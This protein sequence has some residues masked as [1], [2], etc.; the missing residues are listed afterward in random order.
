MLRRQKQRRVRWTGSPISKS[1]RN[2]ILVSFTSHLALHFPVKRVILPADKPLVS[3]YRLTVRVL[4]V[5]HSLLLFHPPLSLG[6]E[7]GVACPSGISD[8]S[9]SLTHSV[10]CHWVFVCGCRCRRLFCATHEENRIRAG[11]YD[12]L[13]VMCMT[14]KQGMEEYIPNSGASKGINCLSN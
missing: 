13:E 2:S 11:I 10:F 7:D 1:S 9:D 3:R 6:Y 8:P 14:G 12:P 5:S 4:L